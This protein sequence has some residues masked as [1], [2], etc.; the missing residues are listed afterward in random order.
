MISVKC[1]LLTNVSDDRTPLENMSFTLP[2]G[3]SLDSKFWREGKSIIYFG[4]SHCPDMCPLAL[5]Q[6]ARASLILGPLAKE[7]RFIFITL[8]PE[9]DHPALLA[10]YVRQFPGKSLYALS[11]SNDSLHQI[12]GLFHVTSKKVKMQGS[13]TIDHSNFIYV[14]DEKLHQIKAYPG[15]ISS[16][17]LANQLRVLAKSN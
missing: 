5:N 12:E 11:P 8:D 10:G 14:L 7:F 17:E 9:R 3:R 6:F 4:F 15:G 1:K 16:V 13:Y 2:D